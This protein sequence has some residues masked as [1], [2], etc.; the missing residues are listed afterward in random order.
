M[1]PLVTAAV[2]PDDWPWLLSPQHATAPPADRAHVWSKPAASAT[3][4]AAATD[5]G[6]PPVWLRRL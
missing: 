3:C 1:P 4:P 5:A 6:T 2:G